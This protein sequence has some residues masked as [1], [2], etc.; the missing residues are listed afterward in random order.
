MAR[1]W[2]YTLQAWRD[3]P[4][5]DRDL[6]LEHE[7]LVCRSCG[8]LRSVCSNPDVAWYPQRTMCYATAAREVTTRRLTEKHKGRKPGADL[9]PL[10]GMAVWVSDVDLT[11]DDDF[12]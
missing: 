9:H 7:R 2:G 6:L 12:V 1:S 5:A 8:N 4:D 10:D 11:P 3:L